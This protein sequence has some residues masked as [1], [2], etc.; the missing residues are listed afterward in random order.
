M[1]IFFKIVA[2]VLAVGAICKITV[3]LIE[4]RQI[5]MIEGFENSSDN[6]DQR[7]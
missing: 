6:N 1:K 5:K 3:D 4:K 7:S 2:A